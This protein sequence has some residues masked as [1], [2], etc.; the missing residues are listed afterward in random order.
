[1]STVKDA[2]LYFALVFGAGFVFGTL[3]VTLL[4]PRIGERAA[5]LIESPFMLAA[6]LL[7]ARWVVG[8]SRATASALLG[9]GL[10]AAALVLVADVAVGVGLR[11]M[12]FAEVFTDRDPIS[13]SVYY[14][15][16]VLFA[17]LPWLFA[18]RRGRALG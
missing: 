8:R 18:R 13:G 5:E 17:L 7:A 11:G 14:A 12:T 15:L 3:R 2:A 1:M 16:V 10:L 4:L 6:M 9:S